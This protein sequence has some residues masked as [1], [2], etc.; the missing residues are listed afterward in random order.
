MDRWTGFSS[1]VIL[2]RDSGHRCLVWRDLELIIPV[3]RFM[4]LQQIRLKFYVAPTLD[5]P[6]GCMYKCVYIYIYRT[7]ASA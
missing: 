7:R 6:R 5:P 3:E 2:L 4:F 1:L